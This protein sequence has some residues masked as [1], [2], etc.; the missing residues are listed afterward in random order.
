MQ[1]DQLLRVSCALALTLLGSAPIVHAD[2]SGSFY[3]SAGSDYSSGKYGQPTSTTIWDVPFT[4][5]Y[6]G[7]AWSF[8]V[9]VPWIRVS[10]PPNVIPGIGVIKNNNPLGRGLGRLLG[11]GGVTTPSTTTSGTAS[12][13]GDVIAQATYHLVNDTQSQFALD[14]TGRVKFG[15]AD[16]NKGLGTGQND[17][18]AEVDAYKGFG[19]AWTAFGGVG[20][21]NLGSST[22]IQLRN[23]WLANAGVNYKMDEA[24]SAGLYVFY[25]QRPSTS[26][27][28]RREAT[29]YYNHKVDTAWSLQ[30]YVLGGFSY[31]SPDY[32]IGASAKYAF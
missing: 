29:L 2:K 4:A 8:R 28:S 31:G 19:N 10:G 9:T 24:D 13:L 3:A 25:Q 32:G 23:V 16:V 6:S 7:Q 17:Y 30:G 12:G 26:G 22:Y 1:R 27:Y 15:T 20:Y 18:G 14:V 11:G 5:G 21:T